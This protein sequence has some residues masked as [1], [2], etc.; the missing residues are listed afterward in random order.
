M[1]K[2]IIKPVDK[3]LKEEISLLYSGGYFDVELDGDVNVQALKEALA[4]EFWFEME[5]GEGQK[6]EVLNKLAKDI[7]NILSLCSDEIEQEKYLFLSNDY[8]DFVYFDKSLELSYDFLA[9]G[10]EMAIFDLN[11]SIAELDSFMFDGVNFSKLWFE[12][13]LLGTSTEAT[14]KNI[15][16]FV[17]KY[18]QKK[19]EINDEMDG[20]VS[21]T[22]KNYISSNNP[23]L[24]AYLKKH[25]I[26]PLKFGKN[27]IHVNDPFSNDSQY[28]DESYQIGEP[29]IGLFDDVS[30]Y[31]NNYRFDEFDSVNHEDYL[32]FDDVIFFTGKRRMNSPRLFFIKNT[33]ENR[34]HF[35]SVK[36][37]RHQNRLLSIHCGTEV[38]HQYD[39]VMCDYCGE[40]NEVH[41]NKNEFVCSSCKEMNQV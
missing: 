15:R 21:Q 28:F 39:D 17:K 7:C 36:S 34:E 32:I 26:G 6:K 16:L 30:I 22:N 2:I 24:L 31:K 12:G 8:W 38:F 37:S 11:N 27:L 13:E 4:E 9:E 40:I 20:F 3:A 25:G 18:K 29:S 14:E 35:L 41:R 10:L 5:T 33:S 23:V 19:E 1:K